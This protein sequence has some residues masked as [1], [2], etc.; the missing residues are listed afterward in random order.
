VTGGSEMRKIAAWFWKEIKSVIP[1]T[2][3]FFITFNLISFTNALNLKHYGISV[4]NFA[5]ATI[6]ALVAGKV[7]LIAD[8]LP[9][10]NR[11]PD[12]PLI[13]NVVWKTIIYS[14][15][16]LLIRYVEHLIG[17]LRQY[18]SLSVANSRLLE[19]INWPRFWSVQIWLLVLIFIYCEF[20][21]LIRV[22][23]RDEVVDMF[24]FKKKK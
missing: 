5:S 4:S 8:K 3:F 2:I 16:A 22:V 15:A 19:E 11:Y 24:F 13:Y 18:G 14:L 12:K 6:G 23:G 9:F 20:R 10:I 1:P 21:E 7:V 17:F